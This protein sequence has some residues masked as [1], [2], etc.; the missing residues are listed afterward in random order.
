MA[1][2]SLEL[3]MQQDAV[4]WNVTRKGNFLTEEILNWNVFVKMFRYAEQEEDDIKKLC[5][6]HLT[7]LNFGEILLKSSFEVCVSKKASNFISLNW[8]SF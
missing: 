3:L 4:R 2:D 1:F 7:F 6:L 5:E 8:N